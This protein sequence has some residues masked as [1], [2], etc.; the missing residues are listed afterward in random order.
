MI[1]HGTSK[2][3]WDL[4]ELPKLRYTGTK[5][6]RTNGRSQRNEHGS[7]LQQECEHP[8]FH[9]KYANRKDRRDALNRRTGK[10]SRVTRKRYR[11]K[12]Q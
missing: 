3:D 7:I 6:I 10:L 8:Y 12:Q 11:K 9:D 4:S 1:A 2:K 5:R